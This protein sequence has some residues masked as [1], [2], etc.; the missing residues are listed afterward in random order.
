MNF[1]VSFDSLRRILG[2]NVDCRRI[3]HCVLIV[4]LELFSLVCG[5]GASWDG[6]GNDGYGAHGLIAK[7]RFTTRS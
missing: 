7:R 1:G 5:I 4:N 6:Q 2:G 3:D